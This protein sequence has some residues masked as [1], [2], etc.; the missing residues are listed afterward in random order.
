MKSSK[1]VYCRRTDSIVKS[2]KA[3]A[4]DGAFKILIAEATQHPDFRAII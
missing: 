4:G 3:S 1:M 2:D